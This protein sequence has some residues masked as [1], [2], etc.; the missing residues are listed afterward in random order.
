EQDDASRFAGAA[1]AVARLPGST[2]PLYRLAARQARAACRLEPEEGRHRT[3]LGMALY[4]LGQFAEAAET[5]R[6]ADQADPATAAFLAMSLRRGGEPGGERAALGLLRE[7]M[8]Q[9]RW[10]SD[11]EAVAFLREVEAEAPAAKEPK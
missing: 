9:H 8:Q 2:P 7:L 5:L 6:R 3:A 11:A 4:R 10:A 1:R